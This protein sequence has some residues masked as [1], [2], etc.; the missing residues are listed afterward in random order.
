MDSTD[1]PQRGRQARRSLPGGPGLALAALVLLAAA[2]YA[3]NAWLVPPLTGYD[4]V[5]HA[6]YVRTILEEGRLPHPVEGW[7]TFHPPLYY[8]VGA[9]VW[10]L[11]E[12]LGPRAIVAGLRAI[13]A[14]AVLAAGCVAFRLVRRTGAGAGVAWTAA[15]LVLF[16][17]CAQM[18]AVMEGNEALGAGLAA[19]ALPSILALQ[20]DPRRLR[21]AA[22]AGLF[23]GLALATKFTGLFV[24]VACAVPFA[25]RLDRAGVRALLVCSALVLAIGGPAYLRNLALTGSP[26]PMTR[27]LEPMRSVEARLELRPRR[28]ADYLW[29]SP[30]CLL[31]P[32]IFWVDGAPEPFGRWNLSMESA[33]GLAYASAWYDPFAQ[34]IP[35][36]FHRDGV[37]P[38]PAL[39]L[40]GL[41]PTGVAL[42]GFARAIAAVARRGARAPDAPL[43][44]M[45]LVGVASFVAFT[46]HAPALGAAKAAYLLPLGVP[47]ALFFA[48]GTERLGRTGR[49]L[50]TLSAA[51][52]LLAALVFTSGLVFPPAKWTTARGGWTGLPEQLPRAGLRETLDYLVPE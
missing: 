45:V 46:W 29:V 47:A 28:L 14:L 50:V 15:A 48:L 30:E 13:S 9:A 8:L 37:W 18:A 38:G 19:L 26:I 42:L 44:A 2:Q 23:V 17:P 31:R 25:R 32:S 12:P 51:T 52:A 49:A 10:R 20:E 39:A 43:V 33:F 24:A 21:A 5:G 41:V 6:A 4:G 16:V 11:L 1:A 22:L 27:S 40:L 34:R 35:M 3:W 36:V 7:S